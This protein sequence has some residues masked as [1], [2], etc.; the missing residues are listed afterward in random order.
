MTKN[1]YYLM[2]CFHLTGD[3]D[4]KFFASEA[5]MQ[6]AY[7]DL[8]NPIVNAIFE[9]NLQDQEDDLWYH[10]VSE[11]SVPTWGGFRLNGGQNEIMDD[12]FT[13]DGVN[14]YYQWGRD[15]VQITTDKLYYIARF[16]EHVDESEIQFVNGLGLAA[17][18]YNEAVTEHLDIAR[19]HHGWAIDRTDKETWR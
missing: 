6:K 16:S 11:N 12:L 5:Q 9:H 18:K 1:V 8:V 13:N 4:V 17:S 3:S 7:E 10:V 15:E 19:M 2:T 14:V